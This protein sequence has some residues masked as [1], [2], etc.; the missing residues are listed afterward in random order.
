ML[1]F[2][3]DSVG[4]SLL[5]RSLPT[6]EQLGSPVGYQRRTQAIEGTDVMIRSLAIRTVSMAVAFLGLDAI[7]DSVSL[8]GGFFGAIG[9]AVVFGLVSA[10][11]GTL[12]RLLTLP[13]RIISF[14]LFDLVING[15]L[16]LVTSWLTDWLEVDGFVAGITG[17]LILGVIAA[18]TGY[19]VTALAPNR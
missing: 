12:I 18:V 16:L 14:G 17:A 11:L 9:L 8:S 5:L 1:L 6:I 19:L 15:A 10:V 13:V 7:M 3:K 4:P 2:T